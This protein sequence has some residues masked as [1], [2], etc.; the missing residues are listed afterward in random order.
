MLDLHKRLSAAKSDPNRGDDESYIVDL[1]GKVIAVSIQ[2]VEIVNGLA[3]LEAWVEDRQLK[4]SYRRLYSE[5]SEFIK[6]EDFHS[7]LTS[8]KLKLKPKNANIAGLQ[9]ADLVAYPSRR[10]VLIERGFVTPKSY[11]FSDKITEI[12]TEKYLKNP[13]SGEIWGWGKKL[14][15]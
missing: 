8:K 10:E 9:I 12:L 13:K 4:D 11:D 14:L 15:P 5:G 1:V 3:K 7:K 2:T 6:S